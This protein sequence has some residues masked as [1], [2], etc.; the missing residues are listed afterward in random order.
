MLP[1][2][3][4]SAVALRFATDMKYAQIGE[5]LGISTDAARRN[6]HEGLTKLRG[7]LT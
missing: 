2:K 5:M 7:E 4:R 6:V 1:P 3:Q